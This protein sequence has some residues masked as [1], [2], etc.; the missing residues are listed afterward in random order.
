MSLAVQRGQS[1]LGVVVEHILLPGS[2]DDRFAR[3]RVEA[4][5][6]GDT[7]QM[8]S[9]RLVVDAE[10]RGDLALGQVG[11]KEIEHHLL[12]RGEA[13]RVAPHRRLRV[14]FAATPITP[15]IAPVSSWRGA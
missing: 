9:H 1:G 7:A 15:A 8:G 14:L 5:L 2:G 10:P 3:R 11:G 4:K 13:R 6:G 12:V